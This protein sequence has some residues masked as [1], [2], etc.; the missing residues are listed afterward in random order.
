[1]SQFWK[2]ETERG[3]L[4]L[5]YVE[6]PMIVSTPRE[7]GDRLVNWIRALGYTD[8]DLTNLSRE[9]DMMFAGAPFHWYAEAKPMRPVLVVNN[10]LEE[11]PL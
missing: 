9:K 4:E 1:M 10:R 7:V 8:Y 3:V 5:H 11:N 6:D 2:Y